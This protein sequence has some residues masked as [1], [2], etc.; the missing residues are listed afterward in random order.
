MAGKCLKNHKENSMNPSASG[1]PTVEIIERCAR[2]PADEVAWQEFVRRFHLTIRRSVMRA[3]QHKAK[4]DPGRNPLLSEKTVDDLVQAVYCR[5][6]E[7]SGQMLEQFD[8]TQPG[9]IYTYLSLISYRIV[10]NHFRAASE[11]F[12]QEKV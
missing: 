2:R 9:S 10:F 5:V 12:I 3:Y 11:P 7:S 8:F 4:D 1:W 6:I